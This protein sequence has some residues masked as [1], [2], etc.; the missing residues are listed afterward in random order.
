VRRSVAILVLV[1]CGKG[2]APSSGSA[3]SATPAAGSATWTCDPLPF[4]PSTPLGEA[5]GVALLDGNL[6]AV[7]DS[8]QH[9]AYA[10]IDPGSGKTLEQGSLPL[11]DPPNASDDLEGLSAWNGKL[12]GL[13]S[14]GWI[15]VWQRADK[16]FQLVAGPYAV[17]PVDLPVAALHRGIGDVPPKTDGM[18]CPIEGTNCGRNYEG[19]CLAPT[20]TGI[21]PL[22]C[23]G[24]A[25][26]KAD[27]HLYCLTLDLDNNQLVVHRDKAIA[28]GRPGTA[29]DCAFDDDGTLWVGHNVFAMNTVQRIDRALDPARATIT[30]IGPAGVGFSEAIAVK[31]DTI[32]RL[33][34]AGGSPSLMGKFRC[35]PKAR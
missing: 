21:N 9:G 32:W 23:A 10:I 8:G 26:S 1:A 6:V 33:S 16:G 19:I 4:E 28:V 11:G 3:A 35:T 17:G 34:D 31:G 24:Y 22:V 29:A 25:L 5:S 12:V 15:R 30:E 18:V 7:G 20:P 27:G 14:A 2:P 13:S